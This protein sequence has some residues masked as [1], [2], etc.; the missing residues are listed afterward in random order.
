MPRGCFECPLRE[1]HGWE[2]DWCAVSE[3]CDLI[4]ETTRPDY[5]PLKSADEM[6]A[7]IE[8]KAKEY[9][10]CFEH[11][12]SRIGIGLRMGATIA[13]KYCDKENK[14]ED[15]NNSNRD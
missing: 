14:N 4:G 1:E 11:G 9:E 12:H 10:S 3:G 2:G 5:C 15:Q 6:I 13:H 7:E 8:E